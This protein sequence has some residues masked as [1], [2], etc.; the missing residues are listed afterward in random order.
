MTKNISYFRN[1]TSYN[2]HL[3]YKFVKWSCLQGFFFH[4][5]KIFIFWV[6][7]W[8]KR[9]KTGLSRSFMVQMCKTIISPGFFSILKFWFSRLSR[10]WKDKKWPKMTKISVSRTLYLR[11]YISYDLHLWYT[12]MYK[13][14]ISPGIF[15]IFCKILIFGIIKRA[16][17][18]AKNGPK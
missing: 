6:H 16:S 8:V 15:F 7:R 13:K 9:Q 1:N 2:C 18:R 5:L 17:K 4:F 10:S 11:N 14:I 3:W 12:C